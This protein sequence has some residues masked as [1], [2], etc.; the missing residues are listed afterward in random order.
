MFLYLFYHVKLWF[1]GDFKPFFLE[2]ICGQQK[3]KVSDFSWSMFSLDLLKDIWSV[4]VSKNQF[5]V[6]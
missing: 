3:H 6:F 1:T 2:P 5:E 4:K